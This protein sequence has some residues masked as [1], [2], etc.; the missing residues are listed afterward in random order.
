MA[1]EKQETEMVNE[2]D[3]KHGDEVKADKAT[4][5]TEGAVTT[6]S[7]TLD[8]AELAKQLEGAQA[9]IR[10]LNKENEKRRLEEKERKLKELEEQGKY[11]E[12][13]AERTAELE[14][15]KAEKEKRDAYIEKADAVFRERLETEIKDWDDE[16]KGLID[17]DADV[18]QQL[19]LVNR[20]RKVHEKLAKPVSAGNTS[21]PAP[22]GGLG[23]AERAKE[24]KKNML[25]QY[26]RNF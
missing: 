1:E 14:A 22:N 15:I 23:Q 12:I 6:D 17:K 2:Q 3:V 5:A 10:E 26:R 13:L 25:E 9:R 18:L 11:K 7:E 24:F 16:L 21:G 20:L 19:D 8:A 4:E